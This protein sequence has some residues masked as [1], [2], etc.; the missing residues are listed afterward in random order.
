MKHM[1]TWK[2][3]AANKKSIVSYSGGKDSTLALEWAMKQGEV[4]GLLVMMEEQGERSRSHATGSELVRAQAKAIGLPVFE[5]SASWTTYEEAFVEAL[6]TAKEA[7][8]EVLVTGDIDLLEHGLWHE[9]VAARAGLQLAM[10][11][12]QEERKSIVKEVVERGYR[13]I[14]VTI[15][16]SLGMK[17]SDLGRELSIEFMN[18]LIE[19]GIDPCGE[20][21][22]FHTTV[23]DGPCF[24][25][26][27]DVKVGR[28]VRQDP[29]VFLEL[30]L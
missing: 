19:R 12:W 20:Q 7:G 1:N 10:P 21:G 28:E 30:M 11:L 26:A 8:A 5:V 23:I 13:A 4:I 29:Y 22:E 9:Q 17:A 3:N 6:K 14:I 27:L 24:Q 15:N 2:Q 25:Q 18:E 16:E